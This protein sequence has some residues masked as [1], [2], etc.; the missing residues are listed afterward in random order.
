MKKI[1]TVI[2]IAFSVSVF[3]QDNQW[4]LGVQLGFHGSHTRF[5]GGMT[6]AHSRFF[7][8]GYSAA[9][10]DFT[11]RNDINEHWMF[12]MGIGFTQTGFN[13]AIAE[14]YSL[15]G[16]G[17]N[18]TS[19]RSDLS[20]TQIPILGA[21]KTLLNC[22]NA[23]WF[24]GGGLVLNFTGDKVNTSSSANGDDVTKLDSAYLNAQVSSGKYVTVDPRFIIG[25]E[26]IFKHGSIFSVSF[27]ANIGTRDLMHATVNYTLDGTSYMHKFTNNGTYCGIV[28]SYYFRNIGWKKQQMTE[29]AK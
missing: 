1:L 20:L 22:R 3:A 2:L 6:N 24:I 29:K 15:L 13:F 17:H 19:I 18:Y 26:K 14:N 25:R 8:D 10:W 28:F 12:L 16:K 21:Y 7:S 5:S 9:S 4:K 27:L 11:A 23:R